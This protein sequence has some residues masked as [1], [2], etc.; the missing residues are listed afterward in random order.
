MCE[1]ALYFLISLA[2]AL[3]VFPWNVFA[4]LECQGGCRLIA[5]AP[6]CLAKL[7]ER[8]LSVRLL[9]RSGAGP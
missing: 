9:F 1:L 6:A 8:I 2:A 3:G 4:V 5:T 7:H